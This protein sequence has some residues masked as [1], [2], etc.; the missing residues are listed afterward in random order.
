MLRKTAWRKTASDAVNW[1]QDQALSTTIF[2]LTESGPTGF[3]LKENGESKN[4]KVSSFLVFT[5]IDP[6]IDPV[7]LLAYSTVK[8][9]QFPDKVC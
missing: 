2:I 8:P 4:Y 1:H 6:V 3:L 5:S 7:S 9:C